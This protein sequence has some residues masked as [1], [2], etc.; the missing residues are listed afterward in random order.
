MYRAC[1]ASC[2]PLRRGRN[3]LVCLGWH[4]IGPCGRGRLCEVMLQWRACVRVQLL[5]GPAV[6]P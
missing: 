5:G 3:I 2:L 4:W 1:S 6:A